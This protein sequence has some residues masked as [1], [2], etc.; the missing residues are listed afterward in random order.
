MF[1]RLFLARN[2][3]WRD[4]ILRVLPAIV[5]AVDHSQGQLSGLSNSIEC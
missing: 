2:V 4:R 3:A 5:A 1:K